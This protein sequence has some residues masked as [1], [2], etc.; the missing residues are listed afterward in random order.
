LLSWVLSGIATLKNYNH[1][2][3]SVFIILFEYISLYQTLS[4]WL[5]IQSNKIDMALAGPLV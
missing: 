4:I 2:C 1:I 5:G 3:E